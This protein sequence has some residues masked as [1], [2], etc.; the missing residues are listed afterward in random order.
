MKLKRR[1]TFMQTTRDITLM[2]EAVEPLEEAGLGTLKT[3]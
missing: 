2:D 3:P 1:K